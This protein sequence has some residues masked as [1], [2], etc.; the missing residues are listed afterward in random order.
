[1]VDIMYVG[2]EQIEELKDIF[3]GNADIMVVK[4]TYDSVAGKYTADKTLDEIT[5]AGEAGKTVLG[6]CGGLMT[7]SD[8]AFYSVTMLGTQAQIKRL[9]PEIDG[10]TSEPTGFYEIETYVWDVTAT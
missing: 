2:D 3:G 9:I 5:D 7:Y 8:Y 4:F 1:M 6:Q 10:T